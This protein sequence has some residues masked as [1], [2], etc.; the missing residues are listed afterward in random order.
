MM[1]SLLLQ[2]GL[3]VARHR[4]DVTTHVYVSACRQEAARELYSR[5]GVWL[6]LGPAPEVAS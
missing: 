5:S 2:R 1:A 6:G 4:V 3:W